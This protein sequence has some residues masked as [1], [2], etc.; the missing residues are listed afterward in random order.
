M[1][2]TLILKSTLK[3]LARLDN[4]FLKEDTLAAE[5]EIATDRTLK[6]E[7]F[8]DALNELRDNG[9]IERDAT[10]LGEPTWH[11]TGKGLLAVKEGVR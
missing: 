9:L 5:V 2:D 7:E 8:R 1:K 3:V 11:I 6:V 10:L 4:V